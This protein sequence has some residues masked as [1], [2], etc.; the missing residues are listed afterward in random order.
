MTKIVAVDW[1]H[2]EEKNK[3]YDGNQ[4][5]DS[6]DGADIVLCENIPDHQAKAMVDN[7][8]TIFR[9][10]PNDVAKYR[11]KHDIEKTDENDAQ[12]IYELYQQSPELFYEYL[13]SQDIARLKV[14]YKLR[15]DQQEIRKKAGARSFAVGGEDPYLDKIEK[16][17]QS[18]EGKTQRQ[19]AKILKKFPIYTEFLKNIEGV[20]DVVAAGLII[21]TGD[22]RR[23][24]NISCLFKNFGLDVQDGKAPKKQK[25]KAARWNHQARALLVGVLPECW[26]RRKECYYRQLI[27]AEKTRQA[28]LHPELTKGHV[29]N[30]AFRYATKHFLKE[31]FK[32][33]KEIGG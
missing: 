5:I 32:K 7:G 33:Y 19:F 25:G 8:I 11:E 17:M 30:R 23:W 13:Y 27:D 20:G 26:N 9:C 6:I 24:P 12:C 16:E 15:M 28:E 4:I 18:L 29:Q 31:F 22:I 10:S 1:A 21:H 14:L 2:K 3:V